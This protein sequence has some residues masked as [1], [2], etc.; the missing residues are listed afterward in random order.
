MLCS[1]FDLF[2]FELFKKVFKKIFCV[3]DEYWSQQPELQD[4]PIYY[5]SSLAKR[6]MPVYLTFSNAMNEKMR[7]QMALRNPF[8][9]R[10]V[11]NLKV[12][13]FT[14]QIKIQ[15]LE[16]SGVSQLHISFYT[17]AYACTCQFIN[18]LTF[19]ELF[20]RYT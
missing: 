17:C 11:S 19:P 18:A 12:I 20:K 7:K 13:V 6:C 1:L 9:F 15:L 14:R 8:A 2:R 16:K 4:V 3:L 5:A 10:H